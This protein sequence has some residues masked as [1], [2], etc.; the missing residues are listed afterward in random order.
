MTKKAKLPK[1]PQC[2]AAPDK[3]VSVGG[4]GGP[5]HDACSQC[6]YQWRVEESRG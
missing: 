5:P 6:G 2:G 3:R 1:C 4:F